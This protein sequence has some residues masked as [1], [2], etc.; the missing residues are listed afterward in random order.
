MRPYRP[1]SRDLGYLALSRA[2]VERAYVSPTQ[3]PTGP[4]VDTAG[5]SFFD[6]ATTV[7]TRCFFPSSIRSIYTVLLTSVDASK[8]RAVVSSSRNSGETGTRDKTRNAS[9][10]DVVPRFP[11]PQTRQRAL[12]T[13]LLAGDTRLGLGVKLSE[14]ISSSRNNQT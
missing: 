5:R 6:G 13:T 9:S 7:L 4:R 8:T 2:I 14:F 12:A 3:T 1:P 11:F 10:R